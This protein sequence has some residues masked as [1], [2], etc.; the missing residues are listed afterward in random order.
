MSSFSHNSTMN[1]RDPRDPTDVTNRS[2]SNL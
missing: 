1:P 2:Q